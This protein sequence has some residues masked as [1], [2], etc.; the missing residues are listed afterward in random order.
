MA[1]VTNSAAEQLDSLDDALAAGGVEGLLA[2]LAE[3]FAREDRLH[4]LFDTRL[5]QARVKLGL[6]PVG[7]GALEELPPA[8]REKVEQAYLVACQEIGEKMLAQGK[9]R[10]AWM[11]LRPTGSTKEMIA[12]I[13]AVEVDDDT[14]EDLIELALQERIDPAYGFELLLT[15]HGTCNSITVYDSQLASASKSDQQRCAELLVR[16]LHAELDRNLRAEIK[17]R[18]GRDPDEMNL[19]A[20]VAERDWL[21]SE[22]NYHVDT[23]HLNSVV[24]IGQIVEEPAELSMLVDLCAYGLKLAKQFQFE[25][26]APFES[27]FP[28]HT[29]Y[30][31]AQLG[32]N[33]EEALDFFRQRAE[34]DNQLVIGTGAA[35]TYIVLLQRLG[36]WS[37]A[38]AASA[39]LLPP[40]TRT[41]GFAP[42]LLELSKQARDF[43]TLKAL[44][45][46]RGDLLN[47]AAAL[48]VEAN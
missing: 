22:N 10:E 27:T 15:Y 2:A 48:A 36:R 47:Y 24:R 31:N 19:A 34:N 21:F 33:V 3:Q 8:Q 37:E 29:L 11:Y 14:A 5:M 26:D 35:E 1:T 30:Y 40:G 38:I 28:T 42:T 44:C 13:R 20:L 41:A 6:P 4:E 32:Q 7:S 17:R 9:L 12:A 23:T 45:R 39:K 46:E 25:G 18:E 43:A 16:H